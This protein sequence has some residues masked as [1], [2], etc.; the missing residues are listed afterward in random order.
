[1][2]SLDEGNCWNTVLLDTALDVQNIRY[3]CYASKSK[4]H[5]LFAPKRLIT[6]LCCDFKILVSV[7]AFPRDGFNLR[8]A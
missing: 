1:M 4:L 7:T 5:C 3:A 6:R 2:F 8:R